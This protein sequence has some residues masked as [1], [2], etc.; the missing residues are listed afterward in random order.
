ML[1]SRKGSAGERI[2]GSD[3]NSGG[4]RTSWIV[5][6]NIVWLLCWR[7]SGSMMNGSMIDQLVG[8]EGK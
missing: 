6:A 3:G 1:W 2:G 7:L 4:P 8:L 5:D